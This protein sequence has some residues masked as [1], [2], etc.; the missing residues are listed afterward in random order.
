MKLLWQDNKQCIYVFSEEIYICPCLHI[1]HCF[2]VQEVDHD[3]FYIFFAYTVVVNI[4]V[5]SR[6]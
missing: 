2:C 5:G 4:G 1:A 3:A 6:S